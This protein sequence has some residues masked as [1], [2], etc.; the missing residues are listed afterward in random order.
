MHQ[1]E[2]I[3]MFFYFQKGRVHLKSLNFFSRG[4]EPSK[5]YGRIA[6][7]SHNLI[8]PSTEQLRICL[9]LGEDRD[10]TLDRDFMTAV[11]KFSIGFW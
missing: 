6:T 9:F 7:A 3:K 11:V 8:D 10:R 5:P 2:S 1:G 4:L